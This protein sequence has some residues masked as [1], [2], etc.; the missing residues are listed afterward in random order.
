M[1]GHGNIEFFSGMIV[2]VLLITFMSYVSG[3][4][5]TTRDS[6]MKKQGYTWSDKHKA[7]IEAPKVNKF[8][9]LKGSYKEC[10]R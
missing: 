10:C 1:K 2:G 9:G 8:V 5:T 7:Y 3:A 6:Y 4:W